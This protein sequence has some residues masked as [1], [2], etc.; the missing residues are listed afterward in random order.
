MRALPSP[1]M[2]AEQ[3]M[4]RT[5]QYKK[6]MKPLLERKRRARINQCL[7]ELKELMVTAIQADGDNNVSKLEK[8]DVL[9][10]TVTHLR[11]LVQKQGDVRAPD[12]AAAVQ[13]FHAGFA[14][15]VQEVDTFLSS[16]ACQQVAQRVSSEENMHP[17][18]R[19]LMSHLH[20]CLMVMDTADKTSPIR[21]TT[22]VAVRQDPI[23]SP[24]PSPLAAMAPY[25]KALHR[26]RAA[27]S[28]S[29]SSSVDETMMMHGD[30]ASRASRAGLLM[31][32]R[33]LV[34]DDRRVASG[35]FSSGSEDDEGLDLRV[36]AKKSSSSSCASS[37]GSHGSSG[38]YS[39]DEDVWRP[40]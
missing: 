39:S 3:P 25:Q 23:V 10:L 24:P 40:W 13:R 21:V 4:S 16:T 7:E 18:T 26:M 27:S 11:K 34:R 6:V 15:C 33:V 29:T 17:A 35:G 22:P 8:A 36:G 32:V 9:E 2:S 1:V 38:Y 20:E 30:F 14:R 31:P 5:M 19:G 37:Y 12:P 28:A